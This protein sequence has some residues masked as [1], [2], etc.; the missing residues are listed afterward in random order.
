MKTI[1]W[2]TLTANGNYA[3]ND[4]PH[5]PK[6]EALGDFAT[7]AQAAGNFIVGRRTFESFQAQSKP[8]GTGG[9]ADSS[10]FPSTTVVVVST[11]LDLPGMSSARTPR[12]ALA[13]LRERGH[14]TALIAGGE[15][16]HNAFLAEDLVDE[17][18]VNVAPVLEDEGF[19]VV[20]PKGQHRDVKLIETK[21]LG[22]GV[23]Q[24]RYDLRGD[25]SPARSR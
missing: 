12:A 5:P 1:L 4:A 11:T 25:A 22:G 8:P 23:V 3:R 24:M 19:K 13:L 17:L 16:L 7:Q 10:P 2:A 15:R 21:P 9:V 20:L 14:A 18:V 6:P